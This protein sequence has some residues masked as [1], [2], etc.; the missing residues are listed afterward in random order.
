M[1]K[2]LFALL[3]CRARWV[4]LGLPKSVEITRGRRLWILNFSA[5]P[6][7]PPHP[8]P[9]PPSPQVRDLVSGTQEP[10]LKIMKFSSFRKIVE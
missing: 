2:T 6:P 10:G 3:Y 4:D 9:Q 8:H 1:V 7:I 5:P